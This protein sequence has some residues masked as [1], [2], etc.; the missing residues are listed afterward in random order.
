LVRRPDGES[1]N[2]I[3]TRTE[4]HFDAVFSAKTHETF[5]F[6]LQSMGPKDRAIMAALRE[7]DV[8]GKTCLDVGPDTGRW[9]TFLKQE[10][11]SHLA[12][13]DISAESLERCASLC[14]QTQKADLEIEPLAFEPDTFDLAVSFEVLEH[15]RDP[16]HYL[17]ELRRVVKNN[18]LLLISLPNMVS[19][20]SRVRMLLGTL[21]VVMASDPTHV[22]FYRQKDIVGLLAGFGLKPEFLSTSFSLN[23]LNPK[24]KLRLPPCGLLSG[25]DDSLL[26]KVRVN[27]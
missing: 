6:D 26:F 12:A 21:P 2:E 16:G 13:V 1:M 24:S 22:G 15:L 9:L 4:S 11:A 23:P 7:F 3:R 17:S 27:K 5:H 20:I 18:G 8:A 10:G 14:G 19:F 25:L